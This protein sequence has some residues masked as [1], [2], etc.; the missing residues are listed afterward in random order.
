M[1]IR[2]LTL[3]STIATAATV[4]SVVLFA[5]GLSS[6]PTAQAMATTHR[7]ISQSDTMTDTTSSGEEGMMDLGSMAY[8]QGEGYN[9]NQMLIHAGMAT[10]K[11]IHLNETT[12]LMN[13]NMMQAGSATDTGTMDSQAAMMSVGPMIESI[14]HMIE[15]ISYMDSIIGEYSS[16]EMSDQSNAND[17][18]QSVLDT[19]NQ[20]LTIADRQMSGMQLTDTMTDTSGSTE[21]MTDT[22][23]SGMMA[24]A[25]LPSGMID[26]SVMLP[27]MMQNV[28]AIVDQVQS[29]ADTIS[30]SDT[31]AMTDTMMVGSSDVNSIIQMLG[32][33]V[34]TLGQ[35]YS[36]QANYMSATGMSGSMG[37]TGTTTDTTGSS[38]TGT[39]MM[40]AAD[41]SELLSLVS[42]LAQEVGNHLTSTSGS[43]MSTADM[44]V[45][46]TTT[47]TTGSSETMTDTTG[48]GTTSSS[49][50]DSSSMSIVN[51]VAMQLQAALQQIQN[52]ADQLGGSTNQ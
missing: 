45:S 37:S 42:T 48:T 31:S 38:T 39:G 21:T 32:L 1:F 10:D 35:A 50:E 40:S 5:T 6:L 43:T 44:S 20:M 41:S 19:V 11:I 30:S 23:G 36:L 52:T 49:M 18:L 2:K 7:D 24:M 26:A 22:T 34:E 27:I 29:M 28:H 3:L 47:D 33:G 13:L 46:G 17:D 51:G 9:L 16:N 12:L 8:N 25:N 14:G 15:S 4:L